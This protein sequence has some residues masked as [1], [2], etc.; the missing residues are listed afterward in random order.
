MIERTGILGCQYQCGCHLKAGNSRE[1]QRRI[2]LRG[3]VKANSCLINNNITQ[4]NLF[5]NRSR[6]TEA[7]ELFDTHTRQLFQTNCYGRTA[8]SRRADKYRSIADFSQPAG[9]FAMAGNKA[10]ITA[11]GLRQRLHTSG[12][13][14]KHGNSCALQLLC[15]KTYMV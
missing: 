15:R 3:A 5:L 8:H 14:G 13:T 11:Q 2:V 7:D 6:R 10:C 4:I 9:V 1:L 12:V